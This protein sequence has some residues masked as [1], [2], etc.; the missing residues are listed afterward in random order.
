MS[1]TPE[2]QDPSVLDGFKLYHYDPSLAGNIIFAIFFAV[3]STGHAFLLYRH[4]TWYF[5]PF[6]VGCLGKKRYLSP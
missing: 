2:P 5:I 6:L 4:R 1:D 3:A